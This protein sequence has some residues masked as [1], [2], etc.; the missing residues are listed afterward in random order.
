MSETAAKLLEQVLALPEADRL[1]I[2][3]HIGESLGDLADDLD[4]EFAAE[5]DRR[6]E[7]V[8]NGTAE[9]V[10]WE[11]ARDQMQAELARRRAARNGGTLQLRGPE[12]LR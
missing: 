1:A 6:L 2:A 12:P 4:P 9:S 7:M 3:D 11:E 10:P 5:L 8:A